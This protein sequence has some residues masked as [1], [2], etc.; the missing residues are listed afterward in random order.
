[1]KLIHILSRRTAR[2]GVVAGQQGEITHNN[3]NLKSTVSSALLRPDE[4]KKKE[5]ISPLSFKSHTEY[6]LDLSQALAGNGILAN[7]S[8]I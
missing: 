4:E 6:G 7:K 8:Q 5:A 1:M 3:I 2:A